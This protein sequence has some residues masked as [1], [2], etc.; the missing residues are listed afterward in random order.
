MPRRQRWRRPF[1]YTPADVDALMDQA[2]RSIV[3]PLRA[4]TYHT[5]I[6]LLA[7]SGIR[8]GG[9]QARPRRR[10]LGRG[11]AADPRVEVRQLW[12]AWDYAEIGPLPRCP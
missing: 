9:H 2:H 5:L 8:I 11:Y 6:G 10:R 3:S 4:A 1:L 7:A 12:Q